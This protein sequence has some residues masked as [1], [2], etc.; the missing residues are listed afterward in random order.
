VIVGEMKCPCASGFFIVV[1][2]SDGTE[3]LADAD[4][5]AP[6]DFAEW[7]KRVQTRAKSLPLRDQLVVLTS[8]ANVK[9]LAYRSCVECDGKGWLFRLHQGT[10]E[11]HTSDATTATP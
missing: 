1:V 7:G 4:G 9:R 2:M 11:H 8:L 5:V 3:H 6:T 10:A